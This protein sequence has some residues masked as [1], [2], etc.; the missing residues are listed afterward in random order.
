MIVA[1]LSQDRISEIEQLM[2][3]GAPYVTP[4]TS[5]DYWM[6]ARL[7]S[8]TCLVALVDRT[9]AGAV[10]AFRSQDD[11]DE[12]YV[13]DVVTHPDHRG[14]GVARGLLSVLSERMAQRGVTRIY[15]TSEPDNEAAHHTWLSLGFVNVP[16][17]REER[18]VQVTADFKGPGRDRAVYEL[19]LTSIVAGRTAGTPGPAER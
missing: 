9:M 7:F 6:Y 15:L 1:P 13:Q 19:G 5:S 2:R 14:R 8:S 17:D 10:I 11:P 16:G 18:G 12:V 3:L 4:R